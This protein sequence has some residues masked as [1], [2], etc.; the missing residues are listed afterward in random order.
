MI[1]TSKSSQSIGHVACFAIRRHHDH[2][3]GVPPGSQQFL[4]AIMLLLYTRHL[5]GYVQRTYMLEDLWVYLARLARLILVMQLELVQSWH[6]KHYDQIIDAHI[7]CLINAK[8]SH[9]WLLSIQEGQ[10]NQDLLQARCS[11]KNNLTIIIL[12]I[13]MTLGSHRLH[14]ILYTIQKG[15]P[16]LMN[17]WC[18][19]ECLNRIHS[20]TWALPPQVIS[21][22]CNTA[23]T[24]GP[25]EF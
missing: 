2:V 16:I 18:Q 13:T 1:P 23:C 21:F 7:S 9:L 11:T 22:T 6:N 19:M 14:T 8:A 12:C 5:I 15:L 3:I 20:N 25:C 4:A 10:Q 17:H 24:W